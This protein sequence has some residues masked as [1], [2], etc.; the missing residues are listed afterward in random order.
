[1]LINALKTSM[2]NPFQESSEITFMRN[3]K[4]IMLEI[5]TILQIFLQIV[6]VMSDY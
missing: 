5:Q 6:D 1:M 4:R 3:E 2:N